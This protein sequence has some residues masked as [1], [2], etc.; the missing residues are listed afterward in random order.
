[1]TGQRIG[2]RTDAG[3]VEIDGMPLAD[4]INTVSRQVV[5]GHGGIGS[6]QA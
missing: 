5:T 2:M 6:A 1:M 3:R 4:I